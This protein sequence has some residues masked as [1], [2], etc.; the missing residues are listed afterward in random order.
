MFNVRI[1]PPTLLALL[2]TPL[3]SVALASL[4]DVVMDNRCIEFSSP[5]EVP[6][7]SCPGVTIPRDKSRNFADE[8]LQCAKA[9]FTHLRQPVEID[10]EAWTDLKNVNPQAAA[11][12]IRQQPAPAWSGTINYST[13]VHW[14]WQEC[15][16]VTDGA[17]CGIKKVCSNSKDCTLEPKTC[18]ANVTV[19]ES[20]PCDHGQMDFDVQFTK[21]KL[22][23]WNV[24]TEGF[25]P[26][27]ANKYDLLAGEEEAITV[28]NVSG[29][30]THSAQLT[31]ALSIEDPKN[32]YHI[33]HQPQNLQCRING[34]DHI[35]FTVDTEKRIASSSPNGFSLPVTY[36]G[37]PIDPLV[38]SSATGKDGQ[39]ETKAYPIILKAQDYSAATI[40]EISR[41]VAKDLKNIIIRIQL[42][43][44]GLFGERL[45]STIY[46]DEAQGIQQTLN[47]L[48]NNQKIRRSTLWEFKLK[49]DNSPRKNL[50]RSYIP[51]LAYYPGKVFLSEEKLSYDN[52]LKPDTEYTLKLTVYQKNMPFYKQSCESE[53]T[54]WDCKWYALW[55]LLSPRRKEKNYFSKKSLDIK[56]HSHPNV[57]M[58]THLATFWNMAK[59]G[60][61][62]VPVGI[63]ALTLKATGVL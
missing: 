29:W 38:W 3:S 47:A 21:P 22:A 19:H 25:I 33:K 44:P 45:R 62:V 5:R 28:T 36:D 43:E 55:G 30:S 13:H 2:L 1:I 14:D 52:F 27:I 54:A 48:S 60:Q 53:P 6:S 12:A 20:L 9:N 24:E 31:P 61:L 49:N 40:A 50:Y 39:L 46:I 51:A 37:E 59:W 41:E 16:L 42:Y 8:Q 10:E 4:L 35:R 15:R 26:R 57:D 18:F 56:F 11:D 32:E 17:L 34:H 23:Q 63:I 7:H 58:R